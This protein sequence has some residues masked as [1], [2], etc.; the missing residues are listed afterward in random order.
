MR[1]YRRDDVETHNLRHYGPQLPAVNVK[2]D[3]AHVS[4]YRVM[5]RFHCT[6]EVAEQALEYAWQS[7]VECFWEE[8]GELVMTTFGKA[9][10]HYG[11]GRSDGWLV[12]EGLPP[13]D[14]WD[15]IALGRWRHFECA[16]QADIRARSAPENV[17]EDI[18][19][20]RWAEPFAERY[21]F[22]ERADGVVKCVADV[23]R[24]GHDARQAFLNT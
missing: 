17:L 21:N 20:N 12:V 10:K 23:N 8:I 14:Q 3:V 9:V 11:A 13:V 15:A 5:E 19:V 1:T 24:A 7:G 6:E 22:I 18:E 16:V 4:T 2:R